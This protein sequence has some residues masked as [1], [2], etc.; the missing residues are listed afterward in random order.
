MKSS[1]FETESVRPIAARCDDTRVHVTLADGRE[2]GAPLWWYPFLQNASAKQRADVELQFSGIWWPELDEGVPVEGLLPGWMTPVV[3][4]LAPLRAA[5]APIRRKSL[6]FLVAAALLTANGAAWAQE[7]MLGIAVADNPERPYDQSIKIASRAGATYATLPLQWDEVETTPGKYS[8]EPDWLG[9]ATAYY[10]TVK[11]KVALEL[12]PID[13]VADRRPQWL[14]GKAWDDPAVVDAYREMVRQVLEKS[15]G[16]D[17]VSFA[18]GNEVDGVLGSDASAWDAYARLVAAARS[19]VRALRPD[20]PIGVKVTFGGLTGDARDGILRINAETDV[21]MIDWYPIDAAFRARDP[22]M[23]VKDDLEIIAAAFPGTEIHLT[24]VG[25]PSSESCAGGETA[26]AEFIHAF[27]QEWDDRAAQIT[28]VYWDWMTDVAQA[29][30]ERARTYYGIAAPCFA[31]YIATLGLETNKLK[32]KAGWT[33]FAEEA[34][35]RFH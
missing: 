10:P 19:E 9:I 16:I 26:Q 21:A 1:E 11:W 35:K 29:E 4:M 31:E 18:V 13:T 34:A 12:N 8:P 15:R 14:R 17:L 32:P 3:K 28:R 23:S 30:V 20:L 25:Y 33:A 22:E 5:R 2:I 6:T 27:F 7:R 24:E